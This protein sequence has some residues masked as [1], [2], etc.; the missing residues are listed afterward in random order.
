MKRTFGLLFIISAGLSAAGEAAPAEAV[1]SAVKNLANASGYSWAVTAKCGD[2]SRIA[3]GPVEGQTEK[4]GC[5]RWIMSFGDHKS[6][7]FIKGDHVAVKS[8]DSWV[9]PEEL[10]PPGTPPPGPPPGSAG[11]PPPPGSPGEARTNITAAPRT[12]PEGGGRHRDGRRSTSFLARRFQEMKAPA[13]FAANLAGKISTYTVTGDRFTGELPADA[14]KELLTFGQHP[15]GPRDHDRGHSPPEPANAKGTVT[16]TIKDGALTRMELTLAAT[17]SFNGSEMA[18]D[19]TTR[20]EIRDTGTT[21]LEIPAAAQAIL[22]APT[23]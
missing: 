1:Q 7:A 23:P 19:R 11:S 8:G 12:G 18:I 3:P 4:G 15:R 2:D 22:E 16:F 6:E 9:K 21:K 17:L 13:E 20:F 10:R 5:T 14:V